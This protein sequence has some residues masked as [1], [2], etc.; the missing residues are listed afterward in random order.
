MQY[1][2]NYFTSLQGVHIILNISDSDVG[3]KENIIQEFRLPVSG[4][5]YRYEIFVRKPVEIFIVHRQIRPPGY[6][7]TSMKIIKGI[8]TI[9][10]LKIPD[11]LNKTAHSYAP[12]DSPFARPRRYGVPRMRYN[13]FGKLN[14]EFI[15]SK[16]AFHF[17]KNYS[18]Y[19]IILFSR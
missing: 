1:K 4:S 12:G 18:G 9:Q 3:K 6:T 10:R 16:S 8:V 14:S 19:R 7:R 15:L 17:F 13:E 11:L 2:K 5:L